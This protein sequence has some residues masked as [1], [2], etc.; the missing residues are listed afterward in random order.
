MVCNLTNGQPNFAKLVIRVKV[1]QGIKL[2][3][4]KLAILP[5]KLMQQRCLRAL[6]QTK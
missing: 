6:G 4:Q 1:P 2:K 3:A 5:S